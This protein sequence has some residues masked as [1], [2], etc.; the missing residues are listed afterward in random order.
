MIA[1]TPP[2]PSGEFVSNPG[3]ASYLP[4]VRRG[5]CGSGGLVAKAV[6]VRLPQRANAPP[7]KK[8]HAHHGRHYQ[9]CRPAFKDIHAKLDSLRVV[10]SC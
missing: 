3:S 4:P 1:G 9:P 10:G 8:H 2:R 5:L 6:T 7:Q